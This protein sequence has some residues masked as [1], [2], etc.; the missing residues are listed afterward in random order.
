M[1]GITALNAQDQG[2]GDIIFK[3]DNDSWAAFTCGSD[4]TGGGIPQ[5]V[6][7]ARTTRIPDVSSR[8]SAS[9]GN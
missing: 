1:G 2:N 7:T 4:V 6:L 9:F 3:Q 5:S 8:Q